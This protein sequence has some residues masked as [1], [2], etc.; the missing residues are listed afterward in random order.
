MIYTIS[1]CTSNTL[2]LNITFTQNVM[3]NSSNH[4]NILM[5]KSESN[6]IEMC[7][8]LFVVFV[9][10]IIS[11]KSHQT[12]QFVFILVEFIC[13]QTTVLMVWTKSMSQFL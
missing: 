3:L 11:N 10:Y 8:V 12:I 9:Y 13:K 4:V 5:N 7:L 6:V 1:M 2:K